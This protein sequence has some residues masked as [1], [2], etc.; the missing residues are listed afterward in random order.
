MW[1]IAVHVDTASA[2]VVRSR[3]VPASGDHQKT[4]IHISQPPPH[5]HAKSRKPLEVWVGEKYTLSLCWDTGNISPP[6]SSAQTLPTCSNILLGASLERCPH[7]GQCD[8][9]RWRAL[10]GP[11]CPAGHHMDA[12]GG[13]TTDKNRRPIVGHVFWTRCLPQRRPCAPIVL[14]PSG[15]QPQPLPF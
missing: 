14:G 13:Q 9:G 8:I 11:I 3:A 7:L 5:A 1:E 15:R 4:P 10:G 2:S 12:S 6:H